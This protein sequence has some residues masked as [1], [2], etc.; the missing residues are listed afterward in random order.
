[1]D[2]TGHRD[3]LAF[4]SLA[5]LNVAIFFDESRDRYGNVKLV[6]IGVGVLGLAKLEDGSGT[7][8]KVLLSEVPEED[9]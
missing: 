4:Q 9:R 8:L 1:M 6:R 2:A 5:G 7:E 3:N